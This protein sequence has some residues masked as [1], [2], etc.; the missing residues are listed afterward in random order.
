[1][2]GFSGAKYKSFKTE[3]LANE[4]VR[5]FSISTSSFSSFSKYPNDFTG[6]SQHSNDNNDTKRMIDKEVVLENVMTA[7]QLLEKERQKLR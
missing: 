5:S 1:M 6:N 2:H 4:Y 3:A 7:D